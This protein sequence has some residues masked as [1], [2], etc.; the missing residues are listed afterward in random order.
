M[1]ITERPDTW[2]IKYIDID[3]TYY[4]SGPMA[5]YDEHNFP[6]FDK[7]TAELRD[8]GLLIMSPHE[9]ILPQDPDPKLEGRDYLANDFAMMS[10]HC[11]GII[12]LKGWPTSTGARAEL[13][14]A[15]TLK[16]PVFYYHNFTLTSMNKDGVT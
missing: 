11:Q 12:L 14:I 10:S 16:W 13:E 4:L 2:G 5:G 1:N 8:T 6:A 15:L 7:A 3:K 9:L